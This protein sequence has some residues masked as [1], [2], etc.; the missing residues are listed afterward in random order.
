MPQVT[1]YVRAEDYEAWKAV[2]KKSELIHDAL[3]SVDVLSYNKVVKEREE[4][5]KIVKPF[6]EKM[7]ETA[8]KGV[9]PKVKFDV[10]KHG[11]DPIFCKFAKP[12]K[13]CK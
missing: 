11:S 13:V 10:C 4:I 8:V 9:E 3:K 6:V 1:V 7:K 12:G 5:Q 2:E